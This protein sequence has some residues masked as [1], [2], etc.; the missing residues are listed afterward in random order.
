MVAPLL[1]VLTLVPQT[2]IEPRRSRRARIG[3]HYLIG[4][5]ACR[6]RAGAYDLT[7]AHRSPQRGS[8]SGCAGE[9]K[10]AVALGV[11][12]ALT[13]VNSQVTS[14]VRRPCRRTIGA[15]DIAAAMRRP[16]VNSIDI[17]GRFNR[18]ERKV[19]RET[20]AVSTQYRTFGVGDLVE[21]D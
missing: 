6:N 12:A 11:R 17:A 10:A 7:A 18:R 16:L 9:T 1:I 4:Y 13:C 14:W 19:L 15:D 2:E 20:Y 8:L 3:A 5:I 21:I